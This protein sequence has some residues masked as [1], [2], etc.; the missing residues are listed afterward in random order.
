MTLNE[1][2]NDLKRNHITVEISEESTD[3]IRKNDLYQFGEYRGSVSF[4][5]ESGSVIESNEKLS[6]LSK[7]L[8]Y[9]R[10]PVN[11][12][13]LSGFILPLPTSLLFYNLVYSKWQHNS[14]F[15]GFFFSLNHLP[16]L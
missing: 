14:R 13:T 10:I 15:I 6:D 4:D 12:A 5:N 9:V 7:R 11:V 1:L 16:G 8:N 2:L 3:I